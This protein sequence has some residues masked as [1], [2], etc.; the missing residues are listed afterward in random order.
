MEE[1]K[2]E[3]EFDDLKEVWDK[4]LNRVGGGYYSFRVWLRRCLL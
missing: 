1:N 4:S 3:V 2:M